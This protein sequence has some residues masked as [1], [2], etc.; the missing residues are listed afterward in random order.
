MKDKYEKLHTEWINN[1]GQVR[2]LAGES[3]NDVRLRAVAMVSNVITKYEDTVILVFHRVV[4]KVLIC[5]LLG[6]DNSHFWNIG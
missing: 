1:P 6:L 2:I 4:N 5:V 3:L